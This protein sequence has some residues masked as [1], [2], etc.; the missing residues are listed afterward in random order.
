MGLFNTGYT[1]G[2]KLRLELD[3]IE[4]YVYQA[5]VLNT[6]LLIKNNRQQ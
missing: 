3:T 1:Y 5:S 2:E 4:L 6:V